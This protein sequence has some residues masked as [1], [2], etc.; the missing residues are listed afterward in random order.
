MSDLNKIIASILTSDATQQLSG[1][2][3]GVV[4]GGKKKLPAKL[5]RW[6]RALMHARE[7]MG[8]TGFLA[9][10]KNAPARSP[11]KKLSVLARR[12]FDR[13]R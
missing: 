13:S 12:N 3:D 2:A 5:R 6:N 4:E 9:P 1:G 7:E 8:I 10:K 11:Q